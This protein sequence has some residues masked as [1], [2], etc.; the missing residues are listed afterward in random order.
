MVT[1][2]DVSVTV[3]THLD[4]IDNGLAIGE[5]AFDGHTAIAGVGDIDGAELV[6]E[7]PARPQF[8]HV[9]V[10]VIGVIENILP[11]EP[12]PV[13]LNSQV[14]EKRPAIGAADQ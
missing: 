12:V 14:A 11:G 7:G 6:F 13:N 1:G 3:E 4:H 9:L 8:F 5:G 10:D 2:A